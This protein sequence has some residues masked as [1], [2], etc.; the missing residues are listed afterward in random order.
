[1]NAGPAE[2]PR[3]P[4]GPSRKLLRWC[5]YALA[6][7]VVLGAVTLTGLRVFLPELGRYRPQIEAWLS[8]M[9]DRQ[10]E[11]GAI[12]VVWRG[13]TPVFRIEDVRLTGIEAAGD[14][15]AEPDGAAVA[16][17]PADTPE[18]P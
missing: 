1:M 10:V 2:S 11:V 15:P 16:D 14:T 13:W 3:R 5:I 9:A 6:G 8:R 18:A 7:A 12:D 17:T 4:D